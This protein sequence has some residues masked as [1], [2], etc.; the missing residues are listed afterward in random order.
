MTGAEFPEPRAI[1]QEQDRTSGGVCRRRGR[2]VWSRAAA[3]YGGCQLVR[4]PA[5]VDPDGSAEEVQVRWVWVRVASS[6]MLFLGERVVLGVRRGGVYCV[7][8]GVLC[9]VNFL[10]LSDIVRFMMSF[11]DLPISF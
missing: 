11:V 4:L 10:P 2:C 8:S 1:L 3:R 6:L 9:Q 5:S 7:K